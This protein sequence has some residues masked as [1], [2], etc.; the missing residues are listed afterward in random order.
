MEV[1]ITDD[2]V[3]SRVELAV[4]WLAGVVAELIIPVVELDDIVEIV[5]VVVELVTTS[6]DLPRT[7]PCSMKYWA[8]GSVAMMS[9]PKNPKPTTVPL[10]N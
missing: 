1:A 5:R 8:E 3:F 4:V 7:I 6:A 2:E 9:S 10:L